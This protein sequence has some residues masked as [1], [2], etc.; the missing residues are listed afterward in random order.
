MKYS[1]GQILTSKEETV[2]EKGLSG[3]KVTIPKGNK[4]IIG[5]DNLAHHIRNGYIQPLAEGSEIDGYSAEGLAEWVYIYMRNHLPLDEMLESYDESRNSFKEN[6]VEALEE[7][8][9]Y[10]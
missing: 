8:G 5:A 2:V 9:F 7:I 3:D 4:V 10:E 6:I 1:I